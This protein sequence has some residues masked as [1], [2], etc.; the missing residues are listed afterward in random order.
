MG[1]IL[2]KEQFEI[3]ERDI[4]DLLINRREIFSFLNKKGQGIDSEE[5]IEIYDL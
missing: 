4:K 3:I 5:D 1:Y 2:E